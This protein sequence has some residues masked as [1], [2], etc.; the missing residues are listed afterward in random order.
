LT[1]SKKLEVPLGGIFDEKE[2]LSKK[3]DWLFSELENANKS[4]NYLNP[5][6]AMPALIKLAQQTTDPE[7]YACLT[8]MGLDVRA[9][10]RGNDK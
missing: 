9:I 5:L 10:K 6:I 8:V 4:I 3:I 2:K 7:L 1:Q